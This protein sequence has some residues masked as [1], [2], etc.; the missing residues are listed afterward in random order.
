MTIFG[1]Y[2]DRYLQDHKIKRKTFA[3]LVGE[4]VDT[5]RLWVSGDEIPKGYHLVRIASIINVDV[6]NLDEMVEQDREARRNRQNLERRELLSVVRRLPADRASF[7]LMVLKADLQ[8]A[9]GHCAEV[10]EESG[11][12]EICAEES[13]E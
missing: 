3:T 10:E 2:L 12:G 7:W 13:A 4:A 5:V 11:A 1:S 6:A 8:Q 9:T